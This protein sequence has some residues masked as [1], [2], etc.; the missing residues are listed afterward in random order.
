MCG[1]F[2]VVTAGGPAAPKRL[3][4]LTRRLFQLSESRGKESSGLGCLSQNSIGVYRRPMAATQLLE[5]REYQSFFGD[6]LNQVNEHA[7][8]TAAVIGHAR[9]VT[10]GRMEEN[11]NNQPVIK[12]GMVAVHNGIITNYESLWKSQPLI[13]REYDVDTE[14]FLA[15]FRFHLRDSPLPTALRQTFDAVEGSVSIAVVFQDLNLL[16]LATNTGSLYFARDE[17]E[18]TLFFASEEHIL[19]QT[20]RGLP[21]TTRGCVN[22][23][24]LKAGYALVVD[25]RDLTITQIAIRGSEP[26]LTLSNGHCQRDIIEHAPISNAPPVAVQLRR[27]WPAGFSAMMDKNVEAV[28]GLRRCQRCILPETV[29]FISF[30]EEGVCNFCRNY[31]APVLLG[32][33]AL[34][35]ALSPYRRHDGRQECII[36]F[37]GG[38]DSSYGLHYLKTVTGVNPVAYSYDWGMITGLARRNQARLCAKL[39]VE[40]IWVSADIKQKRDYVRRNILAWL[41]RPDLGMVPLFMAGDK[42][43]FY[44]ANQLRK[45]TG[46]ELVVL[47]ANPYERTDFKSGFCGIEP[48]FDE[49]S[50]YAL[51]KSRKFKLV[52]YYAGQYLANPAYLNRSIFDTMWA[53]FSYYVMKH[54]YLS[55]YDYIPWDEDTIVSTLRTEYDWETATDTQSSWRIGDGTAPFYNFIY[56]TVAGFTENDTFRSNQVRAGIMSREQALRLAAEDNRF[57]PEAFR[58]Y[59][60]T[61]GLDANGLVER[62][63][64][65]PKLYLSRS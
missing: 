36:T 12:A 40:H 10:N 17:S 28:T 45:R 23:E 19:R 49:S 8:A 15:L 47:C 21:R 39:G 61:I 63:S 42:Q 59:C 20:I 29:P 4:L 55:L 2:G 46:M 6:F 3:R 54:G 24:Q 25:L 32:K 37:S 53:Y 57:R 56:Y 16:L 65:I 22:A 5:T 38:R 58:W 9:L 33:E 14:V 43:Y 41:K 11:S 18:H 27:D 44:Y 31:R 13:E 34:T 35:A 64:A 26:A 48:N 60:D 50:I 30:D 52:S 51:S 7:G 1:I 62:I